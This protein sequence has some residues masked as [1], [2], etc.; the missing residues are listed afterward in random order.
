M[1]AWNALIV[2]KG[3]LKE[4]ITL[5]VFPSGPVSTPV[6]LVFMSVAYL[7]SF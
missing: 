2:Q 1:S 6:P 4:I 5:V 7:F 3:S